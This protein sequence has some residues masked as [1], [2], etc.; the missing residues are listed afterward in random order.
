MTCTPQ[1]LH[2]IVC[3]IPTSPALQLDSYEL[4][5]VYVSSGDILGGCSLAGSP[6]KEVKLLFAGTFL[7]AASGYSSA[8]LLGQGISG[9]AASVGIAGSLLASAGG[10]PPL[11]LIGMVRSSSCSSG[12]SD[13]TTSVLLYITMPFRD[14]GY[15]YAMIGNIGLVLVALAVNAI[16]FAVKAMAPEDHNADASQAALEEKKKATD[17]SS[18]DV[19]MGE[20]PSIIQVA[21]SAREVEEAIR[22][23]EE[24]AKRKKELA[25]HREKALRAVR[26]PDFAILVAVVM[27]Q[28]TLDLACKLAFTSTDIIE[29]SVASAGFLFAVLVPLGMILVVRTF[30]SPHPQP[31][32]SGLPTFRGEIVLPESLL[33]N[34]KPP[35]PFI[36]YVSYRT[37]ESRSPAAQYASP[38]GFWYPK[39][40]RRRFNTILFPLRG[41]PML[42]ASDDDRQRGLLYFTLVYPFMTTIAVTM[43][44]RSNGYSCVSQMWTVLAVF[45]VTAFLV[46]VLQPH[47]SR[48]ENLLTLL[49]YLALVLLT[50]AEIFGINSPP[51]DSLESVKS[52]V[53]I[54]TCVV[55]MLRVAHSVFI[56]HK[57]NSDWID[58]EELPI[59]TDE[60]TDIR[61]LEKEALLKVAQLMVE[62]RKLQRQKEA[63]ERAKAEQAAKA[64]RLLALLDSSSDDEPPAGG[65]V[66]GL[67]AIP[68]LRQVGGSATATSA[69]LDF[70]SPALPLQSPRLGNS[71]AAI[72]DRSEKKKMNVPSLLDSS[73]STSSRRSSSAASSSASMKALAK[74]NSDV[75]LLRKQGLSLSSKAEEVASKR[76][77][78]STESKHSKSTTGTRDLRLVEPVIFSSS[79]SASSSSLASSRASSRSSSSGTSSHPPAGASK[80]QVADDLDFL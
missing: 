71:F 76:S 7:V 50:A 11:L 45:F 48:L 39:D 75:A 34:P 13:A 53:L 15:M 5:N 49:T 68:E 78:R 46:G 27:F 61:K 42:A 23:A 35:K 47:R 6:A 52:A 18:G 56:Q 33:Q 41:N 63:E 66:R 14:L 80:R 26:F 24:S 55:G 1:T 73:S 20:Q 3:T 29:Q 74:R 16:V 60:A 12:S 19:E 25:L 28:G 72:S 4:L 8:A 43:V 62:E 36:R 31:F 44:L 64:K 38:S 77:N 57:E 9:A 40:Y 32:P 10:C 67:L 70:R 59:H 22:A 79:S 69:L 17:A 21:S 58:V 30:L 2:R 37:F 54:V 65:G 51:S